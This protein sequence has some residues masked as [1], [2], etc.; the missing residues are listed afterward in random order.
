MPHLTH[1]PVD[2]ARF[3]ARLSAVDV[4][5]LIQ[6]SEAAAGGDKTSNRPVI[7]MQAESRVQY[8][9]LAARR[10]RVF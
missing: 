2:K 6:M 7:V 5:H 8:G 1:I 3:V 9:G 4:E 10:T